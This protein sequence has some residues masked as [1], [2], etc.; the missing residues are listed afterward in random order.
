M[1]VL[2][3]GNLY[4][5]HHFGGAEQVWASAVR[6]LRGHGHTVRV[7]AADYRHPGQ[8][9]SDEP[10]VSRTLRWYWQEHDF[11]RFGLVKRLEIER[12]NQRQLALNLQQAVKQ[13]PRV[14][15]SLNRRGGANC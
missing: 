10:D 8:P 6:H 15:R 12:H 1:R 14:E 9:E 4:P 13:G 5:P 7:L 3:I 11:A 2:M